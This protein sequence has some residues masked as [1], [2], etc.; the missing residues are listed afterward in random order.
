M[1]AVQNVAL[2]RRADRSFG[3]T[4]KDLIAGSGVRLTDHGVNV[5]KGIPDSWQLY[6][7]D[8]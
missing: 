2:E 1:V 3:R 5:L 7:A 8:V 6:S 4:I